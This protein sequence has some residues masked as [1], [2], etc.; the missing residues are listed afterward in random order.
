M[1]L[2]IS[3]CRQDWQPPEAHSFNVNRVAPSDVTVYTS[4]RG[5]TALAGTSSNDDYSRNIVPNLLLL[6]NICDISAKTEPSSV[7]VISESRSALL[8]VK[9]LKVLPTLDVKLDSPRAS[10]VDT[11]YQDVH[12]QMCDMLLQLFYIRSQTISDLRCLLSIMIMLLQVYR[13]LIV[14]VEP[15]IRPF[16]AKQRKELGNM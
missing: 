8:S 10:Q 3:P 14:D 6:I 15:S 5:I 12:T 9:A 7:D 11:V 16:S 13:I 2:R 1:H 4:I